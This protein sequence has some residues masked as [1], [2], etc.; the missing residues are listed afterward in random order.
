MANFD[1]NS[2]KPG[3]VLK[4][5]TS[6]LAYL[7][8]DPVTGKLVLDVITMS[9]SSTRQTAIPRDANSEEVSYAVTNDSNKTPSP[10]LVDATTGRLI[11]KL[12]L[13]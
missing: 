3:I 9:G 5:G 10:L 4:K 11:I 1:A 6:T 13:G 7:P 8:L 12:I 2:T